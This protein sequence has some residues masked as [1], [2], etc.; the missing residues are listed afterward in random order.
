MCKRCWGSRLLG[1][2]TSL[3]FVGGPGLVRRARCRPRC[4]LGL[5]A[6]NITG[7]C[8][9][10]RL[11]WPVGPPWAQRRKIGAGISWALRGGA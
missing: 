3:G 9:P 1:V 11:A 2:C 7:A 6:S 5:G 10:L 4:S 8:R